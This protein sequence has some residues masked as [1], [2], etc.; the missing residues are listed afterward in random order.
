MSLPICPDCGSD[1]INLVE[2][3]PDSRRH[4]TCAEC[5]RDWLRGD[6]VA[7]LV[8]TADISVAHRRFPDPS[9]VTAA[10]REHVEQLKKT[11]LERQPQVDPRVTPYWTRYQQVFSP[12]GLLTAHPQ[13]FKDFANSNI[14]ANPGNMSV[15]NTAWNNLDEAEAAERVREVIGYLLY[16]PETIPVE[17]RLTHLI[18][19]DRDMGM[20]GFRESLL[21]RVLCV[22]HPDRFLTIL[23]YTGMAGKREIA[24]SVYGLRLP[25]P[26]ATS[27]TPG[28]LAF[29]SNDLLHDLIGDGFDTV[30]HGAAFL[31]WAK[32]QTSSQPAT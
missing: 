25:A 14:G 31:W 20:T 15:F 32:D 22:M 2:V 16:G 6:A 23:K 30:Q 19:G 9:Q 5:A 28:R 3:L 18:R 7:A 8:T 21:T 17:D 24:Q 1:D 13:D 27:A 29:W 10:R 26:D 4:L 12:A 11:F